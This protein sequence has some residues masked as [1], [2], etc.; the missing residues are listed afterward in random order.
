MM[1]GLFFFIRASV[2]DRTQQIQLLPS[3]T[4]DVLLK[5]LQE[6]FESRAYKITQ[7]D[8]EKKQVTF[9]G[10]VQPSLFLAI[11]LSLLAVV[12]F[13][14]LALILFLLF[15]NANSLV[16]LLVMLAPLAGVFYWRKAGRWENILL[17]VV[18]RAD[19]PNLVRVT[20][21]RDEL[22]K[23]EENLSVQTIE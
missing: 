23:L 13:S 19:S 20:A 16:W 12:G 6:Y 17:N 4:E 9:K 11:L 3:E 2:K 10:F 21:H 7:I 22:I 15:P 14:C 8:P 18:S 1:I 5:K